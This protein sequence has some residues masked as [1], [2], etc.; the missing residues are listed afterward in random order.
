MPQFYTVKPGDTLSA[1]ARQLGTT[2]ESL[3]DLN[4][5]TDPDMIFPG[6]VLLAGIEGLGTP[7]ER[8]SVNS[9][10]IDGL[11]YVIAT[12]RNRYRRGETVNIT[13]FKINTTS[14]PRTLTYTTGQRFEFEAVRADGTVVWRWSAGRV[15]TQETASITLQ[16]GRSQVF[17]ASW[18]QRNL[19]GSLVAPQTITIRGFNW[20]Q[21]LRNRFVS[22]NIAITRAAV[23]TP[24][25]TTPPPAVCRPGVNLLENPGFEVWPNP[26]N[27]PSGWQGENVSR[28]ELIRHTG[29]FSA[30]LGTNPRRQARLTQ[31]IPAAAGRIYRLAFWLREIPQVPAGSNFSFRTRVFFF[32]AAGQLISTADPEYN[33]DV[34]PESF[35]QF[36]LTTGTT[37]P[38]TARLEVRFNFIPES[39]NN[40]AVA[41]DDV[42]LECVR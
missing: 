38:G 1:I 8:Q 6:Q 17:R 26:N 25:P 12:D 7:G 34:I 39:G 37:P 27:P 40:N 42:F 20:A 23:P 5:I 35:I 2:V 30:R 3:A 10:V 31:S 41:V 13:L 21:G 15:F 28:Q 22:T 16:P 33:E 19:Q 11:L 29:R 14:R 32:N 18:D 4:Q 36:S 9:R 24:T